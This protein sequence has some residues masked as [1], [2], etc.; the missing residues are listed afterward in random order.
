MKIFILTLITILSISCN[1]QE[2]KI[3]TKE[4]NNP[5]EQIGQYV[6]GIFE[7]SNENL[8][9]G[10]IENGIAK[11]DGKTLRYFTKKDGL[12][13]NRVTNAIEDANGNL[14]FNTDNGVS[15]Y[16]NGKFTNY[17]ID[18]D[19]FSANLVSQFFID[20]NGDFWIGTWNGVYNFD[21]VEFT[22]FP[23]PYPKIET[24]INDDTK[25]WITDIKQDSEGNIWF[26]RDGYGIAKYDGTSFT[27]I[28]KKNGLHSNNVTEIEID[29]QNN[30]W[31][32]MRNGEKDNLN[33]GK[34][35]GKSGINKLTADTI[36]S[37]PEIDALT[38][39]D[40]YEIYKDDSGNIWISTTKNGVYK[41]DG[42]EFKNYNV[43]I[44]IMSMT[45]DKK[46]NLWLGGAGGLYRINEK[47]K[48]E[49]VGKNGPWK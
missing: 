6:T 13:S 16:N 10:T 28:F 37:F 40:V 5:I 42:K 49:N 20:S 12:P 7:D 45:R 1:S 24:S 23:I 36:T 14:W 39:D 29:N 32:G 25:N 44:S 43:P 30:I 15:K 2:K 11:Y 8:W 21:G 34:P 27:H 41:F 18:K 31:F 26:S 35:R 22:N 33:E 17:L 47:G 46:G 3:E 19:N 9:F 48:I 38:N 4:I